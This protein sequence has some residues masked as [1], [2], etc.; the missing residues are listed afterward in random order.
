MK[1]IIL[2]GIF[3]LSIHSSVFGSGFPSLKLGSDAQL[4]GM[5][6]AGTAVVENGAVS[7]WNPAGLPFIQGK[8]LVFSYHRWIQDVQSQFIGFGTG[9]S[10]WGFGLHLLYTEVGGI[11]YRIG[12]PTPDPLGTFSGHEMVAG[13]SFAYR[14][15]R[16]LSV[17]LSMKLYYQKL[18]TDECTG[19]GG[20]VGV[21][22]EIWQDGLRIGGVVQN[23]GKTGRLREESTELP[24]LVK[25][26]FAV[27]VFIGEGRLLCAVDGVAEQDFPFHLHGG[28]EYG[29]Q[30]LLYLRLGYQTGYETR[31]VTGGM[32]VRWRSTRLDY[33]YAPLR[34]GL[35][36]AHRLS[37]GFEW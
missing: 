14:A 11:E 31:W 12:I 33:S 32:G 35:G 1:K 3:F 19:L 10:K 27:P 37:L 36:D 8:K 4:T 16:S 26:G 28:L 21:L 24:L 15:M 22:Y 25:I 9:F 18:F 29:W 34:S 2:F 23:I 13:V 30:D 5:G 17:G 6:F 20:D 7:F